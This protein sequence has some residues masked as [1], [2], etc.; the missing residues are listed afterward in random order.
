[1]H[2]LYRQMLLHQLDQDTERFTVVLVDELG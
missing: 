2:F 1:M